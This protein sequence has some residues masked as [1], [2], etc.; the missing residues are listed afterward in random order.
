[1]KKFNRPVPNFDE[2]DRTGP[3]RRIVLPREGSGLEG[4]YAEFAAHDAMRLAADELQSQRAWTDGVRYWMIII[5]AWTVLI[6]SVFQI[7]TR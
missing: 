3:I 1:M 4:V 6:G 5:V 7:V 2:T